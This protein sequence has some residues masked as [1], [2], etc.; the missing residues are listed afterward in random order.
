[1]KADV[2]SEHQNA[3]RVLTVHNAKGLEFPAVFLI[4]VEAGKVILKDNILY[5]KTEGGEPP[6]KFILK[7]EAEK[8]YE[9][10]F[11]N[12]LQEEELRVLYVAL[13]R[14]CQYLFISGV[15][16]KS[17]IWMTL[18][19]RFQSVFPHIPL[20]E[21]CSVEKIID[22]DRTVHSES[23]TEKINFTG[24]L[25]SFTE[26]KVR[27]EY[28]YEGTILGN[29]AHKLMYEISEGRIEDIGGYERRVDFYL[30]KADFDK[31]KKMRDFLI[32]TYENIEKKSE[33][34]QIISRGIK[35]RSFSEFSFISEIKGRIYTGVIDRLIFM[36]D[37]KC[38]IYDYKIEKGD[39][40]TFR[41]QMD[42]Y[43]KAVKS[44]FPD[45]DVVRRFIIFLGE[46][47]IKEI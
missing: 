2:F 36:E 25:T 33:L 41:E 20:Q 7:R 8:N 34:M 29:I 37:N 16:Q 31:S 6:Y 4:N 39:L 22:V 12:M 5:R 28:H 17:S 35:N 46:G 26:E 42:V 27:G 9:D 44:I 3:V 21:V 30:K 1:P 24:V 45:V 19:E 43:E 11:K 15:K 10:S 18:L 40:K 38:C 13:T 32:R 47:A 23:L 14:A